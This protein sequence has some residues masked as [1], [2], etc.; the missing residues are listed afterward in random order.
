MVY[1]G[2]PTEAAS[3]SHP[4]SPSNDN[5]EMSLVIIGIQDGVDTDTEVLVTV[6]RLSAWI[7]G[8]PADRAD[9]SPRSEDELAMK[10]LG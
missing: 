10:F 1:G 4:S 3:P 9:R 8:I 7:V 2:A 6:I 5:S